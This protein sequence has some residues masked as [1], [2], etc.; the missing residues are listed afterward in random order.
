MKANKILSAVMLLVV[1]CVLT[2]C[3]QKRDAKKIVQ[4]FMECARDSVDKCESLYPD[5]AVIKPKVDCDTFEVLSGVDKMG[6]TLAVKVVTHSKD[7]LNNERND[8]LTFYLC[9][10]VYDKLNIIGSQG[11]LKFTRNSLMTYYAISTGANKKEDWDYDFAVNLKSLRLMFKSLE[12]EI[13]EKVQIINN[14]EAKLSND[15]RSISGTLTI[16]NNLGFDIPSIELYTTF[17]NSCGASYLAPR[18]WAE[19]KQML[20][21]IPQGG[22]SHRVSAKIKFPRGFGPSYT[23]RDN[24]GGWSS[25]ENATFKLT[26][27][28]V[29]K[30]IREHHFS[31]HEYE[32]FIKKMQE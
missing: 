31:G 19:G 29:E 3:G 25:C 4:H 23:M 7:L 32:D 28:T 20:R 30:F 5:F 21:D 24:E 27:E 8:S 2:G 15:R 9:P 17:L 6:D 26:D 18:F 22:S 10:D 16:K 12:K 14:G 11:L 13:S 1:A